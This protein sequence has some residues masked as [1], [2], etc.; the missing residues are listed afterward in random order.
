M[1]LLS[2]INKQARGERKKTLKIRYV[3]VKNRD[4]VQNM[5]IDDLKAEV[6]SEQMTKFMDKISTGEIKTARS[7]NYKPQSTCGQ[8]YDPYDVSFTNWLF[9]HL[10]DTFKDKN[11]TNFIENVIE[12]ECIVK[13]YAD[14][15]DTTEAD[16]NAM[17][18]ETAVLAAEAD[19]GI[20]FEES[21]RALKQNVDVT[22]P[23]EMP[24]S[25][26][27]IVLTSLYSTT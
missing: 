8:L 5:S 13:L 22:P 11:S 10:H 25:E 18:Y 12:P 14:K 16:T 20:T 26:Y 9:L 23:H 1:D 4:I 3:A 21:C 6:K 2:Q 27:S 24:E 17:L 7:R 19:E 15:F